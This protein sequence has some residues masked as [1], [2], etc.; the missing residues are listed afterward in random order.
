ME[1]RLHGPQQVKGLIADGLERRPDDMRGGIAGQPKIGAGLGVPVRGA[2]ADERRD[3]IDP[4]MSG[5]GRERLGLAGVA[6]QL[7]AVA[8]PLDRG[9]GDEDAA[10]E[11]IGGPAAQPIGDG[12]QQAVPD[13]PRIARC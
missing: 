4:A 7:E 3:Q 11:R 9:A 6:D 5:P 8:Q 2:E 1:V 13:A 10:L 12:R